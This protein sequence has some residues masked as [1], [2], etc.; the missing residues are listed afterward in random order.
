MPIHDWTRVG[1]GIFN[2]FLLVAE[3]T[4]REKVNLVFSPTG[5]LNDFFKA[6]RQDAL[7]GIDG[8]TQ[9]DFQGSFS[10][11]GYRQNQS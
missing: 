11:C 4:G 5:M 1:A 2:H 6:K 3:L 8:V 7:I 10:R 9:T